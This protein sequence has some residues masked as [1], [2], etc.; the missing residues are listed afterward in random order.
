MYEDHLCFAS[1]LYNLLFITHWIYYP[2]TSWGPCSPGAWPP[3]QCRWCCD[4][5]PGTTLPTTAP[6]WPRPCP[7]PAGAPPCSR[8]WECV[9]SAAAWRIWI[10]WSLEW[11]TWCSM[12]NP[13]NN[14]GKGN[15][16]TQQSKLPGNIY[17][18][19]A[20]FCSQVSSYPDIIN[21]EEWCFQSSF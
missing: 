18:M 11:R 9:Y 7:P 12:I 17:V 15:N 16:Q 6:A 14:G 3:P 8:G 1:F 10:A 13:F 19:N 4:T 2:Q 21:P 5:A 20:N